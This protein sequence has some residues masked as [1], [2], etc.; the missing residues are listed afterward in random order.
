MATA[1][2]RTYFS[3]GACRRWR[4][5][6]RDDSTRG[7]KS[8]RRK[9]CETKIGHLCVFGRHCE[10]PRND[11][12]L[13]AAGICSSSGDGGGQH[14]FRDFA[15][16]AAGDIRGAARS[17]FL[18]AAEGQAVCGEAELLERGIVVVGAGARGGHDFVSAR[19]CRLPGRS[20]CGV[21]E[22][23]GK[24]V[25]VSL[26]VAAVIAGAAYLWVG[27]AVPPGQE[28]LA[29]LTQS[30]FA[31]FENSFDKSV[32]GPRLVLLLSPT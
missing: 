29:T 8:T 11:G 31:E 22:V 21:C 25:A 26:L 13:L 1:R 32:D 19:D 23:K 5:A 6:G 12:M 17:R 2:S 20:I 27:S 3:S 7:A 10:F 28:P 15:A 4:F 24:P 30:N 18:A 14:A 16:V 9:R